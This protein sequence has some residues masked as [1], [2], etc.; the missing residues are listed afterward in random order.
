MTGNTRIR[1]LTIIL[2]I[3]A[4]LLSG[5]E[6]KDDM[7]FLREQYDYVLGYRDFNPG[8]G[9]SPVN[10]ESLLTARAGTSDETGSDT[11]SGE[12]ED[13]ASYEGDVNT[14]AGYTEEGY[15]GE[16]YSGDTG[17]EP[18]MVADAGEAPDQTATS[19]G[20]SSET[21]VEAE[22]GSDPVS[23]ADAGAPAQG[24]DSSQSGNTEQTGGNGNQTPT[25][26]PGQDGNGQT[27][28]PTPATTEYSDDDDD[29]VIT[30]SKKYG[31]KETWTVP[32][33]FSVT[34]NSVISTPIRNDEEDINPAVVYLVDYTYRNEGYSDPD[35]LLI[36]VDDE[37]IDSAGQE[38]ESYDLD[39][40]DYEPRE[41]MPGESCDAQ[42][43]IALY[44]DGPFDL[45]VGDYDN[46]DD[47]HEATFHIT[48]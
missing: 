27:P 45:I 36:Y 31:L 28:T 8:P 43:N 1:I 12:Y 21:P 40:G 23:E 19:E 4:L 15:S 10:G 38:G 5:C 42:V 39:V 34:I 9:K 25:Q 16:E 2:L 44:N 48:P 26:T 29:D 46:N 18:V 30:E 24:S 7:R 20:G 14:E 33:A 41:I 32:G 37:I 3:Q 35:G 22:L 6:N 13:P 11:G 47:Y 17:E